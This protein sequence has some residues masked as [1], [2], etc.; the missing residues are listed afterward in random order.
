[1]IIPPHQKADFGTGCALRDS[2]P[3]SVNSTVR[4]N[5]FFISGG[6]QLSKALG[7]LG[8]NRKIDLQDLQYTFNVSTILQVPS[9][10]I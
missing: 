8:L 2:D 1:M 10:N 7:F 4:P 6:S 5:I 3:I 9:R